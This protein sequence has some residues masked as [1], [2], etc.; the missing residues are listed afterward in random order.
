M[1]DDRFILEKLERRHNLFHLLLDK[2]PIPVVLVKADASLIYVNPAFEKRVGY[3]AEEL[4][5]RRPPYPWWTENDDIQEFQSALS[6][7]DRGN[8][9]QF[10]D[11]NGREFWVESNIFSIEWEEGEKIF[12]SKWLDITER[13]KVE[14]DLKRKQRRIEDSERRIKAFSQRLLS[15]REEEKMKL[16]QILHS[17]IGTMAIDLCTRLTM[18][19]DDV[20]IENHAECRDTVDRLIDLVAQYGV[21]LRRI[22]LDLHP[23]DIQ[24]YGL[25]FALSKHFQ[26]IGSQSELDVDFRVDLNEDEVDRETAVV[27]F[28]IAQE[29]LNNVLKHARAQKVDAS[30]SKRA[31]AV[32]LSLCDDGV[33]CPGNRI[34]D[35]SHTTMGI[36]SMKE[37]ADTLDGEFHIES[38]LGRGTSIRVMIP[39]KGNEVRAHKNRFGG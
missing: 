3:S 13:K 5:G 30:L 14:E 1:T 39:L 33:G 4:F 15:V 29:A 18:L 22:A 32:C 19:R 27:I 38:E 6:K 24:A 28:R 21:K 10:I 11:R 25:A 9:H 37:L 23:R 17:E 8:E 34:L 35:D 12:V 2:A 20:Q 36:L 31:N 16:S 26:K 7:E